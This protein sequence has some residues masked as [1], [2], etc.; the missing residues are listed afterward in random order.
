[1]DNDVPQSPP[2]AGKIVHALIVWSGI[3]AAGWYGWTLGESVLTRSSLAV[4]GSALL[5][6]GW[7]CVFSAV[8]PERKPVE[9]VAVPGRVLIIL[10]IVLVVAGGAALWSVWHRAAG[11]TYLTAA[12]IDLA[13]R[14]Y[15]LSPLWNDSARR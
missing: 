14:Y 15:R 8:D 5:L 12:F 9:L 4:A 10:E 1:M 3:A 11:E 6:F 13:V 2:V 7:V